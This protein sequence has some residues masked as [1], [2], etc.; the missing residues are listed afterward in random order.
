M[1]EV[2]GNHSESTCARGSVPNPGASHYH[3]SMYIEL[4]ASLTN[5]L[6][7]TN[8]VT[9]VIHELNS[10]RAMLNTRTCSTTDDKEGSTHLIDCTGK[11][12]T[13]NGCISWVPT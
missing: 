8:N 2:V 10:S 1:P 9:V 11:G 12:Q 7:I 4:I 13:G 3:F 5:K 6:L